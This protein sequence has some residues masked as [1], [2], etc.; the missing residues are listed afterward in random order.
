MYDEYCMKELV[1]K[2]SHYQMQCSTTLKEVY[3]K[4]FEGDL[5]LLWGHMM[6]LEAGLKIEF[7]TQFECSGLN[8]REESILHVVTALRNMSVCVRQGKK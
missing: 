2:S 4:L 8:P 5:I 6:L 7:R 1:D 3:S